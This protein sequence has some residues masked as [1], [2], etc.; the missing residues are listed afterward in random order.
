LARSATENLIDVADRNNVA[1]RESVKRGAEHLK[2]E[3]GYSTASAIERL[4]IEQ[5]AL[6]WVAFYNVQETYTSARF[7]GEMVSKSAI[8]FW[9]KQLTAAQ[10]R[11]FRAMEGLARIRKLSRGINVVQVNIA[12]E[13]GQQINMATSTSA[14]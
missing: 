7:A 1:K 11:Y 2:A 10:R 5:V 3:L 13:G 14:G 9:D 8:E 4:A 6:C 12:A